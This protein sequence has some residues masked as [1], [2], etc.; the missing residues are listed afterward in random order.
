MGPGTVLGVQSRRSD[1]EAMETKKV[2]VV[3]GAR[4]WRC[5]P[6]QL[7][8]ASNREVAMFTRRQKTPWTF[9]LVIEGLNK[10]EFVEV[11]HEGEPPDESEQLAGDSAEDPDPVERSSARSRSPRRNT[12]P[13]QDEAHQE[14]ATRS[15]EHRVIGR[16]LRQKTN[17]GA[18]TVTD[19][20]RRVAE[21]PHLCHMER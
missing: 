17:F 14:R 8:N 11:D 12:E 13:P 2:W 9:G 4:L 16:R 7:C 1:G 20:P 3:M 10:G 21:G 5:A 19:S 18:R 6:E 15:R